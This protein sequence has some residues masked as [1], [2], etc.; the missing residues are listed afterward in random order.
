MI[1]ADDVVIAL[2]RMLDIPLSQDAL[3]QVLAYFKSQ[4][5]TILVLDNLET[6]WLAKDSS[7]TLE[8][9]RLLE[10]LAAVRQLALVETT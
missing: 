8:T 2:C 6:I 7:V 10:H 4:L 1:S 5:R 9:E 3:D